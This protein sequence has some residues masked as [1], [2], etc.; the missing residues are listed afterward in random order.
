M[1]FADFLKLVRVNQWYK[2]LLIFLPLVFGG[3]FLS[4]TNLVLILLGLFSL[5]LM[6]SVNYIINDFVDRKRDSFN[7]EKSKKPLV[8]GKIKDYQALIVLF[9]FLSGS[10]LIAL[11]L[12]FMF[13][14]SV[15]ALFVSSQLYSL[16][17]KNEVILDIFFI[18][19]NF[20]IRVISGTFILNTYIS[21]WLVLCPFFLSIYLSVGKREAELTFLGKDAYMHRDVLKH[22]S[23]EV[24]NSLMIVS[25]SL[26]VISYGLYTFLSAHK[27]LI[28]TMPLA[29]YIVFRYTYLIYSGSDIARHPE[30]FL[31]DGRLVWGIFFW[32]I[33]VLLIIYIS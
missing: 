10:L 25:T 17:F 24:T 19:F 33:L 28:W 12:P 22:Y 2:N 31:K 14:I 6:S 8:T 23:K 1:S 4:L 18:A 3:F 21:P 13:F 32:F 30:K 5:C 16:F 15:V 20:V 7:P 27:N 29:L 11:L 9:F 26:L